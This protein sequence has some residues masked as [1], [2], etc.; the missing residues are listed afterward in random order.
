MTVR[1]RFRLVVPFDRADSGD[2]TDATDP[3]DPRS[4]SVGGTEM[5]DDDASGG[6]LM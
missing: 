4:Y 5:R 6:A 1:V 2:A 3:T